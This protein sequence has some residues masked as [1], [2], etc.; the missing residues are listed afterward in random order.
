MLEVLGW[1]GSAVLV[2][3]LLQTRV[4]RLR[5]IN[6]LGSFVLLVFNAIIQVWPMVG[7]N[8]ALAT[9]NLW[10]IVRMWRERHDGNV[11]TVLGVRP[12][13]TYLWHVLGVHGED[14][15]RFNPQLD[16]AAWQEADGDAWLVQKGDET[17]GVVLAVADGDTARVV[18]DWVTPRY[19]DFTPGEFVWRH[20]RLLRDRGFRHVVTPPGMVAPYYDRL[21]FRREGDT[22]VL[23][24]A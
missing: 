24:L 18:L 11:F 4:L 20:S 8:A 2:V 12:D 23:D 17:V 5:V 15:A 14:I 7:M 9:I 13:D 21:G 10:F 3:S 16:L 1:V 22:W 19:R 6:L